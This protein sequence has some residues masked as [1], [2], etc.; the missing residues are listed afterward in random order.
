MNQTLISKAKKF[1]QQYNRPR[2]ISIIRICIIILFFI[3]IFN[4]LLLFIKQPQNK[5][6]ITSN[7]DFSNCK[8]CDFSPVNSP[9]STSRD[10]IFTMLTKFGAG[11]ERLIRSLRTTGSQATIVIFTPYGVTLP[12]W[13]FDCGVVQVK[14]SPFT[15][16]IKR[17]PYK[18]RWEWYYE[19]LSENLHKYD[20]IFHTDAF[21]AFF[22]GDPFAF[23]T[24]H[25]GLYFQMEDKALRDCPYNKMWFLSC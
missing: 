8:L 3:L 1:L 2:R 20:R 22:F 11:S 19:Y 25:S 15:T 18:M 17:S 16:R 6:V 13:V 4:L 9:N 12:K 10:A 24:D 14:S 5:K 7:D 21:D 23:A